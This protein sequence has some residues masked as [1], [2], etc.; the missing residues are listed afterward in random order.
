[1]PS[2]VNARLA[3]EGLSVGDAFGENFFRRDRTMVARR[4]LPDGQWRYTDDTNMALSIYHLLCQKG[5]IDQ[6][7]L[8]LG[9]AAHY[10]PLRGYGPGAGRL[11][12]QIGA[13]GHWW[14]DAARSLFGGQGSYGN[15][16]AMRIAPL[17]GFFAD[18]LDRVVAQAIKSAEITH[19]HPEGIAGAVAIAVAVALAVRLRG[20]PPPTRESLIEMLLPCVP[21]SEVKS[22]LRRAR[23]LQSTQTSHATQ[24]LG[25]GSAISAQDTVPFCIWCAGQHLADFEEALWQTASA[26]GDVDT[27]CAIVG[28]IV[29]AYV[30]Q[31]GIPAEWICRRE[32]LPNWAVGAQHD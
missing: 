13:G 27:N 10:D 5:E 31:D 3:L 12:R 17:G 25:N 16:A 28:G 4:E 7:A 19:A 26:F 20:T 32:P 2:V 22:G 29:A 11:L 18:D 15:G 23:D 8:A 14:Q 30:G 21:E 6:D 24:M 1:M 9:F